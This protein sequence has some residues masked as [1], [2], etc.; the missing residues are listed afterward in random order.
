MRKDRSC[1]SLL[2]SIPLLIL[3]AALRPKPVTLV[4]TPFTKDPVRQSGATGERFWVLKTH[5]E[6]KY[7]MTLM[8]DSRVYRG[9]SP[10]AM[11]T[12]LTDV[13]IFNF[14]YSGG[15]LNPVMYAAAEAKLAPTSHQPS[16]VLGITPLSLTPHAAKNEH[17]LQEL[18]RPSD[19]IYLRLYGLSIV[20]LFESIDLSGAIDHLWGDS[21]LG[22][23][24]YFQEFH[25]DEGW[26]ASWNVPENQQWTLPSYRDLFSK[27]QVSEQLVQELMDQTRQ[28]R[29]QG[30]RVY[31]FRVPTGDEMVALENR[32]SGF[33]ETAFIEQFQDAGGTWFSFP[34]D[35][36]YSY[37]G[38]HLIKQSALDF[39]VDLAELIKGS[40][41]QER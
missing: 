5:G 39:S 38:S 7:D 25:E 12:V 9:I 19:Y 16:I 2:I 41:E 33:D 29:E 17:Y 21:G 22:D 8:G 24:G 32:M 3:I 10:K 27:T 40:L 28:W 23:W 20:K 36:Y 14:G 1:L 15:G 11:E 4:V 34:Q 35:L 18:N 13:R 37:D 31:A 26:I 6:K 30:I